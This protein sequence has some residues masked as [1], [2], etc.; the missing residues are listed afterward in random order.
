MSPNSKAT[1]SKLSDSGQTIASADEDIRGRKVKDKDG[2]DVGRVDDLLID[3][4]DRKVRFLRV[5]HGGF[6]GF[7]ETM[8]FI[9]V[10]AITRI[11]EDDVFINHSRE[12]VAGAPQYDPDLADLPDPVGLYG[13]YGYSPFWGAG[14]MY[15]GYPYYR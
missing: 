6:L 4:Q 13:Y 2:H 8:S 15:P 1:L 14:Y 11:T 7:G 10:D 12:D 3:D 5:E 9:P